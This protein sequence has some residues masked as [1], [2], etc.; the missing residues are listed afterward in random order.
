[1]IEMGISVHKTFSKSTRR[2]KT[3]SNIEIKY[4]LLVKITEK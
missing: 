1:M 4:K 2:T 3:Y